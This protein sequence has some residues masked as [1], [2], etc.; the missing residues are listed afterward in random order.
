M[1]ENERL[2]ILELL[3]SQKISAQEAAD[4]LRQ[5]DSGSAS[6][7][8]PKAKAPQDDETIY[9]SEASPD[10]TTVDDRIVIEKE[11]MRWDDADTSV[12]NGKPRWLKIR[13]RDMNSE[14]NK[15]T[16]NVP[17][18]LVNFGLGT[19]RRFGAD[20]GGFDPEL[21]QQM[22]KEG[23]KGILVDVQDD[24]DGEHVQIYLE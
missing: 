11:V 20:M 14:R 23:H 10:D 16:V 17:L 7:A 18:W 13:V 24:E 15:V 21:L 19:A 6:E 2:E 12:D 22:V 8:S 1:N 4:M 5:L 3:S 9:K